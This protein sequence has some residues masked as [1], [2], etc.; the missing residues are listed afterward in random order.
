MNTKQETKEELKGLAKEIRATK[1]AIKESQR[2]GKYDEHYRLYLKVESLK[3]E[4][5]HKHIAYCLLRGRTL[6]QIERP[7]T[8]NEPSMQLIEKYKAEIAWYDYKAVA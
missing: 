4:F 3:K 7:N 8:G 5:R 2:Q 6:E 1:E